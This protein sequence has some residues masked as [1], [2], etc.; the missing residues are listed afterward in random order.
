M[1]AAW[2]DPPGA[3]K[4]RVLLYIHGGG[5]VVGSINS[6]KRIAGEIAKVAGCRALMVDYRLAPEHKFPA[7]V[8][9]CVASYRWLLSQGYRPENIVIAGDSAGGGLTMSTLVA[10]RD[11]GD[12]LPAAGMLL[13]PGTDMTLEGGSIISNA[14]KDAMLNEK[15]ARMW[16]GL[17]IGD[18]DPR[19]PLASPV[20]ANLEGLPPLY[21]QAGSGEIILDCARQMAEAAESCS[22]PVELDIFDEMFHDWQLFFNFIPEGRDA[23]DRLGRFCREKMEAAAEDREGVRA[24]PA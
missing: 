9:D 5:W 20:Y 13:C 11:A 18:A 10:L 24:Q 6:H 16:A 17:Y 2:F 19:D 23:V 3:D 14:R 21:I 4:D 12:P 22:V 15:I 7:A 1:S 8:D